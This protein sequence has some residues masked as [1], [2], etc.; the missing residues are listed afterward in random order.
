[1]VRAPERR[2]T[3]GVKQRNWG[4]PAGGLSSIRIKNQ[5]RGQRTETEVEHV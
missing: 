1:M 2:I 3:F 4:H 5:P